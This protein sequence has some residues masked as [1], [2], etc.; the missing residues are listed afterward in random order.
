MRSNSIRVRVNVAAT[1]LGGGS[2]HQA[3]RRQEA[4][5]VPEQVLHPRGHRQG[6]RLHGQV[7]TSG[8]E[9]SEVSRPDQMLMRWW[10]NYL[11]WFIQFQ[12]FQFCNISSHGGWEEGWRHK[13]N[14]PSAAFYED[15]CCYIHATSICCAHVIPF[16]NTS[17]LPMPYSKCCLPCRGAIVMYELWPRKVQSV[18]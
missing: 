3:L 6:Q 5:Q 1:P 9:S 10:N 17:E 16:W 8:Y 18:C 7:G 2:T 14:Q 15:M 12:F 11:L 4:P 13:P